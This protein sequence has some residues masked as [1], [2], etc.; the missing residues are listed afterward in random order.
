MTKIEHT[1]PIQTHPSNLPTTKSV[2]RTCNS[3]MKKVA[4]VAFLSIM[5][6]A[7][8][9]QQKE[10]KVGTCAALA[11]IGSWKL[12]DSCPSPLSTF[13]T[14]LGKVA[15]PELIPTT[16]GDA[17]CHISTEAFTQ[18]QCDEVAR[19]VEDSFR[20]NTPAVYDLVMNQRIEPFTGLSMDK[21]EKGFGM[22]SDPGTF[23]RP[24]VAP[25]AKIGFAIPRAVSK[26]HNEAIRYLEKTIL[27]Q[28]DF[29]QKS[30]EDVLKT[31][32]KAHRIMIKDLSKQPGQF[33]TFPAFVTREGMQWN[34]EGWRQELR[35]NGGTREDRKTLE[36]MVAKLKKAN[37]HKLLTEEEFVVLRKIGF[38]PSVPENIPLEMEAFANQLKARVEKMRQGEADVVETAAWAHQKIACIHPFGDG[39]GRMARAFTNMILQLGGMRGVIFPSDAEYTQAIIQDERG[40]MSF[41]HYLRETILWNMDDSIRR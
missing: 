23:L 1:R 33:R 20:T 10:I 19:E 14:L 18:E 26:N 39:N 7:S 38:V 15:H 16:K 37:W 36:N 27:G 5:L 13:P 2:S 28:E 40:E 29:F 32:Q 3:T 17:Y 8:Q 4:V 35:A 30:S 12:I 25:I 34:I 6:V 9:A 24:E 31:M 11:A 41:A 21:H 22:E